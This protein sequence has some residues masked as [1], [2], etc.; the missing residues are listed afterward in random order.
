[1]NKQ[2][3]VNL[4]IINIIYVVKYRNIKQYLYQLELVNFHCHVLNISSTCVYICLLFPL[5]L[6]EYIYNEYYRNY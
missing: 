4:A 3:S 5:L 2:L 6:V 1:M